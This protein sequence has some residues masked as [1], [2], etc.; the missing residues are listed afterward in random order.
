M[1]VAW[2]NFVNS[3]C[4]HYGVQIILQLGSNASDQWCNVLF[5]ER[6]AT[7]NLQGSYWAADQVAHRLT[8]ISQMFFFF[9]MQYIFNS[10]EWAGGRQLS[11]NPSCRLW[12]SCNNHWVFITK[13]DG[14]VHHIITTVNFCFCFGMLMDFQSVAQWALCLP[15]YTGNYFFLILRSDH[16][17]IHGGRN[18]LYI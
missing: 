1:Y 10:D 15:E 12:I 9:Y 8:F 2:W 3:K 18:S 14:L 6:S 7:S 4:V 17:P 11:G 16:Q 13:L 5:K